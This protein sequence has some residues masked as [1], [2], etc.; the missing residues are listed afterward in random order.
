MFYVSTTPHAHAHAS[1]L[2]APDMCKIR[3]F[4]DL[5]ARTLTVSAPGMPDLVLSLDWDKSDARA[6]SPMTSDDSAAEPTVGSS[7]YSSRCKSSSSGGDGDN[8]VA[9]SATPMIVRVC[10]NR[11]PGIICAASTSA[12]FTR[13]L[14]VPCSLV[15]AASAATLPSTK[16]IGFPEHAT[17]ASKGQRNNYVR[18]TYAGDGLAPSTADGGLTGKQASRPP[19][20]GA[21]DRA[22]ANEAQYLLISLA[23]V[24]KVNDMIRESFLGDGKRLVEGEAGGGTRESS[25]EKVNERCAGFGCVSRCV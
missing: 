17:A 15:R 8:A 13:F 22:F 2:Q 19:L 5:Q 4:V 10:G 25:P 16:W 12:W 6:S 3:P 24:A 21:A 9:A 20:G 1:S 11:R 23:S 18:S 7:W 14:G